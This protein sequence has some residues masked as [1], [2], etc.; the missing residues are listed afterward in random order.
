MSVKPNYVKS[1]TW[2]EES[3]DTILNQCDVGDLIYVDYWSEFGRKRFHG[4][5]T[6]TGVEND[7]VNITIQSR[8]S[9]VYNIRSEGV[10]VILSHVSHGYT[11]KGPDVHRIERIPVQMVNDEWQ[12]WEVH[13][14]DNPLNISDDNKE[15][16]YVEA[17][18]HKQAVEFAER[19]SSFGEKKIGAVYP[20]GPPGY[21]GCRGEYEFE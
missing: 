4:E 21:G 1:A 3:Y 15:M 14:Y 9:G 11:V 13:F 12:E 19:R 10:D 8:Y 16:L 7:S 20:D 6:S 18:T 2:F 5:I 17:S